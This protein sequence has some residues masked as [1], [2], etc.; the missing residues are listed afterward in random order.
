MNER[1]EIACLLK[2]VKDYAEETGST[3]ESCL[4]EALTDWYDCVAT[5]RLE[6]YRRALPVLVH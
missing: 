3:P 6:V 4:R 1:A 2:K 5:P